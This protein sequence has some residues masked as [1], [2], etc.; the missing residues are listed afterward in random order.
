MSKGNGTKKEDTRKTKVNK[1]QLQHKV[2][3][4][5][6]NKRQAD[7]IHA[8]KTSTTVICIGVLGSAKTYIPACI[9]ADML[10]KKLVN[11]IVVA[12]PTE[13]KGKSVG[14]FKGTKDEKLGGW[15]APVTDILIQQLG[16]SKYEYYLANGQIELLALEQ[17]KGKSMPD[18]FIIVDEAEDLQPDVAKSLVTRIGL[19]S[20]L[21]ITG[22]IAQQDLLEY[23]GLQLLL[24]VAGHS[25]LDVPVINFDSWEYCVRSPEAKAWGMA[26]ESF[27][28]AKGF[29]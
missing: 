12:R 10:E 29:R 15:C 22:D 14:F 24:D 23:S 8:V 4:K 6:L 27:D 17:V 20:K 5:P 7:Y 25:N 16:I 21:V 13:G 11:K 19:R 18:T 28:E 26:F 3:L 1:A 9:A 2:V